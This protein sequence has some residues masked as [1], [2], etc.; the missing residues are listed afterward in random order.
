MVTNVPG[1]AVPYYLLGAKS[2]SVTGQM[3]LIGWRRRAPRG[4]RLQRRVHFRFTACRELLPDADFYRECLSAAIAGRRRGGGRNVADRSPLKAVLATVTRSLD[5]QRLTAQVRHEVARRCASSTNARGSRCSSALTC[6]PV[7][8]PIRGRSQWSQSARTCST[9]TNW[10]PVAAKMKRRSRS[11]RGDKASGETTRWSRAIPRVIDSGG[12][13]MRRSEPSRGVRSSRSSPRAGRPRSR[14]RVHPRA[15]QA[16]RSCSRRARYRT[17]RP[18]W[19]PACGSSRSAAA[20]PTPP[21]TRRARDRAARAPRTS[22][23]LNRPGARGPC[24]GSANSA[25]LS[26]ERSWSCLARKAPKVLAG[27]AHPEAVHADEPGAGLPVAQ[28]PGV[29][30]PVF[31]VAEPA[32]APRKPGSGSYPLSKRRCSQS[33]PLTRS[34]LDSTVSDLGRRPV[35]APRDPRASRARRTEHGRPPTRAPPRARLC[36]RGRSRE[37]HDVSMA[38]SIATRAL[39]PSEG[40]GAGTSSSGGSSLI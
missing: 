38:P 31:A 23:P 7:H 34:G 13:A 26:P 2:Y 24:T 22:S 14:R 5:A 4:G 28:D 32:L 30:G 25:T 15:R 11:S 3:P 40:A 17:A 19:P 1:P 39:Y 35:E 16:R 29:A 9:G 21:A 12:A 18:G 6:P 10:S 8:Q 37:R 36:A 20:D 27:I 33:T